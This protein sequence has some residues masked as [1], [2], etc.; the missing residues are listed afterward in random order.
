MNVLRTV[1][2]IGFGVL[3]AAGA[4]FN[5]TYTRTHGSEFYGS[6]ADGAWLPPARWL[7]GKVVIPNAAAVTVV[8]VLYEATVA[9]MVLSRGDLVQPGLIAGGIFALTGAAVSSPGGIVANLTMAA[10]LFILAF[11]R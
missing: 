6:F 9:V 10:A 1:V 4:V 11:T 3:F 5:A 7:I 8:L 2:E